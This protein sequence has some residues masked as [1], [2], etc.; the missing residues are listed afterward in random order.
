MMTIGKL[1]KINLAQY[2]K[3]QNRDFTYKT[4]L[5]KKNL[6]AAVSVLE[7]LQDHTF[8]DDDDDE[9]EVN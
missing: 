8:T 7:E 1:T 2:Q 9:I 5:W 4:N 6:Q 3:K